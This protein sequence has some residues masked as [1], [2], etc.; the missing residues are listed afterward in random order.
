[1]VGKY[2]WVVF[3]RNRG[4]RGG[5][6]GEYVHSTYKCSRQAEKFFSVQLILKMVRRLQIV[7]SV[8]SG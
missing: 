8:N 6:G 3:I 2:L 7:A 5:G 4:G 1:M